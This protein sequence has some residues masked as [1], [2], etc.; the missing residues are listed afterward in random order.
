LM[1]DALAARMLD[2]EGKVSPPAQ[3]LR[4]SELYAQL[5]T[6]VWSELSAKGDIPQARRNLQREF[7]NRL[8]GLVLRP[9]QMSRG[10]ARSLLRT[11]AAALAQRLEQAAKRSGLSPE[12]HAHL[13]DSAENLRSALAA[14]LQRAG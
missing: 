8:A 2:N 3:P 12:A 7:V 5:E 13:V 10:D 4:L 11:R 1:S 14:T 9:G 6:D